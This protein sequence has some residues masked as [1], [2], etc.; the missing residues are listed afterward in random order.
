MARIYE[1]RTG[2][3]SESDRLEIARLLI[4]AGYQVSIKRERPPGKDTGRWIYY[5][6][7]NEA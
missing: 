6:E 4:K 1:Q 5:V 3:L 7:Y 2:S